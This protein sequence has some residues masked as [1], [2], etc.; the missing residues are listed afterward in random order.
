MQSNTANSVEF[1]IVASNGKEY[2]LNL[3]PLHDTISAVTYRKKSDKFILTLKK[4]V[5]TTW[6][7]LKKT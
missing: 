2:V 5:E 7:S 3:S 1:K 6:T 4:A